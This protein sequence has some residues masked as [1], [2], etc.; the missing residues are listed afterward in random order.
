MEFDDV[1][2]TT[3]AAREF[4][5][6]PVTDE[7]LWEI[8]DTARFAPSGGNRQGAHVIVV[9]DPDTKQAIAEV[10]KTGARRYLAQRAAGEMPWNVVHPSAVT[11]ADLA[12]TEG[13][14]EFVAPLAAAP[15]LLVVTVNLEVVASMDKDLDR[16]GVVPGGSIYPLVWNILTTARSRGFGGTITTMAVTE[17]PGV[18]EL[19]A[20]P[21]THAVAAVLP[22]GKPVKQL[23]RLRRE[24][25]EDFVTRERFDGNPF[26]R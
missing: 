13:V 6:D 17:E 1:I 24:P 9:R 23:T 19:L 26:T 16:I 25:V 14:D 2:R 8:L 22:L 15:V 11:D 3:F 12:V 4:T 18:R 5:D 21:D 20:I 10:S 7:V